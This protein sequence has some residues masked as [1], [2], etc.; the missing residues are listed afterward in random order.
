M[1]CLA[2]ARAP[3]VDWFGDAHR[4]HVDFGLMSR[5]YEKEEPNDP[6]RP[7]VLL[8]AGKGG[9]LVNPQPVNLPEAEVLAAVHR[10]LAQAGFPAAASI[11]EAELAI[12]VVYGVGEYPPPF[13]FMGIDPLA[14]PSFRW[15]SLLQEYEQRFFRRDYG[16]TED[17]GLVSYRGASIKELYNFIAVRAFDARSLRRDRRWALLWETRVTI[18]AD[19][20]PLSEHFSVMLSAASELLGTDKRRGTVRTAPVRDGVV[21]LGEIEL[22]PEPA[23]SSQDPNGTTAESVP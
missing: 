6:R 5:T 9:P 23:V 16:D 12:V 3:A 20:Y 4:N 7:Y 10:S 21:T 22:S 8:T 15:P 11:A 14:V 17:L 19:G 2:S 18:P 1:L 13:E